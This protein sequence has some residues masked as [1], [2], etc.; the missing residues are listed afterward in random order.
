MNEQGRQITDADS[1][2]QGGLLL[3]CGKTVCDDGFD[4]TAADAICAEMGY[5][6]SESWSSGEMSY[7]IQYDYNIGL[8]EVDCGSGSWEECMYESHVNDC[9]HDED[10]FLACRSSES[11]IVF[12]IWYSDLVASLLFGWEIR[13]LLY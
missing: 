12:V 5:L 8:D 11:D 7:E 9:D 13:I 4:D 10:V 1:V 3:Y 6:G 2:S